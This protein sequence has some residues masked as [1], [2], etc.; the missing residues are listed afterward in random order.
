MMQ[1]QITKKS[2]KATN[3]A[4][5]FAVVSLIYAVFLLLTAVFAVITGGLHCNRQD[6]GGCALQN[7]FVD[8]FGF[9]LALLFGLVI[10]FC[11]LLTNVILIVAGWKQEN[12]RK[13][14]LIASLA[15]DILALFLVFL[16]A[17]SAMFLLQS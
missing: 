4:L 2:S 13:N 8:F 11:L 6:F 14:L 15:M 17:V 12:G 9:I 7:L 10:P 16:F 5:I 3:A 1:N